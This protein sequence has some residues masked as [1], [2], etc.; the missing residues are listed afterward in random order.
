MKD[1]IS[2]F[3]ISFT[4]LALTVVH[5]DFKNAEFRNVGKPSV[6]SIILE[7]SSTV[8]KESALFTTVEAK[9]NLQVGA[10]TLQDGKF[11]GGYQIVVETEDMPMIFR[12]IAR[13]KNESGM[14]SLPS[15]K[16]I[17][18][19]TTSGGTTLKG[20]GYCK[21]KDAKRGIICE[22]IPNA[23]DTSAGGI[24]KLR[25]DSGARIMHF[26]TAYSVATSVAALDQQNAKE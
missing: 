17:D 4:F 14:I 19:I 5:A 10:L 8:V 3:L 6:N 21:E 25:I 16:S 26:E 11:S 7:N 15:A 1:I 23:K 2:K 18:E 13:S 12:S 9:V 20:F 22:V 24:V